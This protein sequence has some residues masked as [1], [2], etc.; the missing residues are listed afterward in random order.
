MAIAGEFLRLFNTDLVMTKGE[1]TYGAW[2]TPS[3]IKTRP[4]DNQI[5]TFKVTSALEGRPNLISLQLYGTEHLFWVLIAFNNARGVLN[6]PR[7]GDVI[8]YPLDSIVL[9]ELL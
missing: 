2:A 9:P 7:S 6:W 1:L 4:S 8:E 3:F 5:R